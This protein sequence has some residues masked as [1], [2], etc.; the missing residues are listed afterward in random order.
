MAE[1]LSVMFLRPIGIRVSKN[2]DNTLFNQRDL[3]YLSNEVAQQE[4]E[5]KH[6]HDIKI[7][8]N[9]LSFPE[10]KVRECM[11]PRTEIETIE[12]QESL[13]N[14]RKQF[15]ESG[16]SRILVYRN[17]PDNMIGYINS[18]DLFKKYTDTSSLLRPIDF[19]PESMSAQKLLASFFK[20][21][22]S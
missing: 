9:A 17:T 1:W 12:E 19:V 13:D 14:L 2:V 5:K 10:V 21:K 20:N 7:F 15:F 18:K 16:Y 3:Y 6:T 11:V 8:Q 22:H 4:G